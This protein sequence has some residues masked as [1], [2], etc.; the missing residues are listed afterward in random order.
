MFGCERLEMAGIEVSTEGLSRLGKR[1]MAELSSASEVA[2]LRV[3]Y[4]LPGGAEVLV[5]SNVPY[6]TANNETVVSKNS[7]RAA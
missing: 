6:A 2:K 4:E 3:V 7:V 1:I 5:R